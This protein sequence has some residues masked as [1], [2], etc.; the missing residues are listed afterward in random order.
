MS[1]SLSKQGVKCPN[2]YCNYR[3]TSNKGL[4]HHFAHRPEC[5]V[6]FCKVTE[7]LAG[8]FKSNNAS[9]SQHGHSN[10]LLANM[11]RTTISN[12][13]VNDNQG[14]LK[15]DA[16]YDDNMDL[17][18]YE[19]DCHGNH[20]AYDANGEVL[21]YT[22]DEDDDFGNHYDDVDEDDVHARWERS[23]WGP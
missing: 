12:V 3:G 21:P 2:I 1:K 16:D 22:D 10:K 9:T 18:D 8:K 20:I 4:K 14:N 6:A 13:N 5:A 7:E 11:N 23:S 19:S 15:N 17:V